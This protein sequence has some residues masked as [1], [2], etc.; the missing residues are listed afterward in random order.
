MICSGSL[1]T[2]RSPGWKQ[3]FSFCPTTSFPHLSAHLPS[4]S[5][6]TPP[7]ED[8]TSFPEV[9]GKNPRAPAGRKKRG[10]LEHPSV[11]RSAFSEVTLVGRGSFHVLTQFAREGIPKACSGLWLREFFFFFFLMCRNDKDVGVRFSIPSPSP[12]A[13]RKL[14]GPQSLPRQ[15]KAHCPFLISLYC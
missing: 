5:P 10:A 2:S 11:Q 15:E 12:P 4:P 7:Q 1:D 13:T 8:V 9:C 3:K 6:T 14:P